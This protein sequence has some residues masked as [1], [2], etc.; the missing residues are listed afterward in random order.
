MEWNEDSEIEYSEFTNIIVSVPVD[1][2]ADVSE[3]DN[4]S[5]NLDQNGDLTWTIHEMS[6]D[7]PSS[8]IK[9]VTPSVDIFPIN[10]SFT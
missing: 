6:E 1:G 4:S 8:T 3:N 2:Q 10:L 9:F 5:Y 7:N